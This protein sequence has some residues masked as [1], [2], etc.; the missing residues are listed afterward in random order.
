MDH[1]EL[2]VTPF[3]PVG[4]HVLPQRWAFALQWR[5]NA[6]M[7]FRLKDLFA[8]QLVVSIGIGMIVCAFRFTTILPVLF[9]VPPAAF[10]IAIAPFLILFNS[11]NRSEK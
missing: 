7:Q 10:L 1:F 9:L 8:I 2:G 5:Y 6:D 3:G 11:N 4:V